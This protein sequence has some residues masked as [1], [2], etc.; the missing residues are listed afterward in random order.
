MRARDARARELVTAHHAFVWRSLKRL[1]VALADVDDAVQRVFL[2]ALD[3]VEPITNVRGFLFATATRVAANARR[4]NA[5]TPERAREEALVETRTPESLL[6][7]KQAREML[8]AVLDSLPMECRTVLVLFEL[9]EL[10][11]AE[12][13]ELLELAPGTVASR[14]RRARELVDAELR[15]MRAAMDFAEKRR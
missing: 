11:M 12:I 10:E 1:G 13:A 14:L 8:D 15:R 2:A 5:R 7:G 6:D 3:H 4:K 9:E